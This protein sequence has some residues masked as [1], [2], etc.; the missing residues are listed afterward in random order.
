MVRGTENQKATRMTLFAKEGGWR[1]YEVKAMK[2]AFGNSA[3]SFNIMY[4][5]KVVILG[6][7]PKSELRKIVHE[8]NFTRHLIIGFDNPRLEGL[9]PF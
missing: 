7:I 6:T 5:D 4:P 3:V 1:K 2:I 8:N 9:K